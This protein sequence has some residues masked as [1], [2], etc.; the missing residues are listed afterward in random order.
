MPSL[1]LQSIILLSTALLVFLT[2]V[3]SYTKKTRKL[4]PSPPALPFIG[5]LYLFKKPLH[6]TLARISQK[7]GPITF[8]RFGSRPV[9]VI[10]SRLL[11][12]ECFTTHDLALANRP[13]SSLP[14]RNKGNRLTGIGAAN[15]GPYWRSLRRIA[16]VEL[17]S[18]QQLHA[19]S[20]IRARE[21][22]DMA[23]RL[24]KSWTKTCCIVSNGSHG[25]N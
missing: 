2:F 16:A 24:F 19:S 14:I 9:L 12:E 6:H 10:S 4:P 22:E 15:Y 1:D 13:Q 7:Y 25:M 8:L 17:L 5:H 11:A 21:V 23:H 18:S 3:L 20:D